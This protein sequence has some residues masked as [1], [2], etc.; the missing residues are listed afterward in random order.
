MADSATSRL[1]AIP[2]A[3]DDPALRELF[4]G[5]RARGGRPLN[6]HLAVAHSPKIA[7]AFITMAHALRFDAVLPRRFRELAILRA[8]QLTGSR[9]E[10]A[11]HHSMALECGI[12]GAQID[13]LDHWRE[14]DRYDDRERTV[15]A[16]VECVASGGDVDEATFAAVA[17]RFDAREIVELTLTISFYVAT[18][19]LLKSLEVKLEDGSD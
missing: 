6:L 15:L 2:D 8:A 16:Y 18:A 1:P 9:Y 14:S 17:A 11:Q 7:A 19:L 10:F 5:I 4:D 13:G 3:P 12:S